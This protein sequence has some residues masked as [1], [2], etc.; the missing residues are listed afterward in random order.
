M[1]GGTTGGAA[2]RV[3]AALLAGDPESGWLGRLIGSALIAGMLV[4]ARDPAGWVWVGYGAAGAGWLVFLVA[5]MARPPRPGIAVAALA[6][7]ALAA[8]AVVGGTV[9]GDGTGTAT[10]WVLVFVLLAMFAVHPVPRPALTVALAAG[11]VAVAAAGWPFG[12]LGVGRFVLFGGITALMTLSAGYRRQCRQRAAQTAELLHQTRRARAEQARAAAL[13][14]R[15]R[16]AREIHDVLAHSLGALG[17]Q[18][19][20]AEALLAEQGDVDG[21]L[22]RLRRSRRLAAEGL[23]EARAAVAALRSDVAPLTEAVAALADAHRRDHAVDPQV[24]IEG[25]PRPVTAPVAVPIVAVARE[26]LTNAARHAPGAAVTIGLEF[27]ADA[28]ALT[29][30]NSAPPRTSPEP[31]GAGVAGNGLTGM[32]ERLALV[33][34]HLHAGPDGA[35][36]VV[37]AEVTGAATV[38]DGAAP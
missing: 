15:T 35:G 38:A 36:W 16:I 18:L 23:A 3:R 26:A 37:R 13:D 30:H 20:V 29:V 31:A 8:A 27:A 2:A 21:A 25:T 33:G 24:H 14:E 12:E 5:D 19:E 1:T 32:R 9:T 6:V 10:G 11:I 17:V 22:A 7:G 34:G 28:V 4:T